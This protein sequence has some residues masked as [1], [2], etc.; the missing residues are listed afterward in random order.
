MMKKTLIYTLVIATIL[1]ASCHTTR[2]MQSAMSKTDTT[3]MVNVGDTHRDSIR[4]IK[5]AFSK[6]QENAIDFK[7]FSA[8]IKTDYYNK[9]GKGPDLTIFVRIR[10]DS[11]IWLSINATVFSYEAFRVLV[12]P[13]SV[14][15]LNKKDKE[16]QFLL[17]SKPCRT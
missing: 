10:K 14:K 1:S 13:D 7:T 12:T 17:T 15:I 16:V 4:F 9:D 6:V 8:K 2:K 3:R 5:T 11:A